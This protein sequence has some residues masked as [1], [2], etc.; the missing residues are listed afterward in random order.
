M[1]FRYKP[2]TTGQLFDL[3]LL[4]D[5]VG[6]E[7]LLTA[8]E[9]EEGPERD[10]RETGLAVAGRL[11]Q[12]L[13]HALPQARTEVYRFLAACVCWEDGSEVTAQQVQALRAV[14]FLRLVQ[15]LFRQ[16][17]MTDF[18]GALATLPGME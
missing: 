6:V 12:V 13:I 11:A 15:G 8:L 16:E 4:L 7:S 5:A 10:R 1:R 17:D 9:T 14:D 18:F 2:F 3:C